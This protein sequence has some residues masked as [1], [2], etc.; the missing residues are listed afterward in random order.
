MQ[1]RRERHT[2]GFESSGAHWAGRCEFPGGP[3]KTAANH[4]IGE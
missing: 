3:L 1:H 4:T 2:P